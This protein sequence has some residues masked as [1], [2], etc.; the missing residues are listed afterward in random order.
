M[1]WWASICC[2][3][4]LTFLEVSLVAILDADKE[5]FLKSE[6]SLIQTIGRAARNAQGKAILYAD[7]IP[8][9]MKQAID[10]TNRRRAIQEVYNRETESRRRQS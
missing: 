6:Q 1:S 7:R 3:K 10:E 8:D 2:V 4:D 5:G 9:S